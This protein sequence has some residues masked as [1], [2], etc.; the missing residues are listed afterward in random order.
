MLAFD[1]DLAPIVGQQVT[2]TSTNAAVANPRIDLLIARAGTAFA[3][4]VLGGAVTECDLVVKGSIGG[5]A[6]AGASPGRLP[7]ER[8]RAGSPTPRCARS[9][10]RGRS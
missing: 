10:P 7:P 6:R 5:V 1:T 9:P 8:R 2:L 3:S 4:P